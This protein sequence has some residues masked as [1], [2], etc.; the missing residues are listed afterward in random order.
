[1]RAW[2]TSMSSS[3]SSQIASQYSSKAGWN[4]RE[5]SVVTTRRILRPPVPTVR[6]RVGTVRAI[7]EPAALE[8]FS[9]PV[10]AWFETS[11]PRA[12]R[13][14][15][16][17][18]GDRSPGASTRCCAPPPGSG[19]TLA[20]FLWA[21]DRFGTGHAG[22]P[23][24]A[25]WSTSR[26][27][28]RSRSTSRRTCA[29]RSRGIA[30][31][32]ERLGVPFASRRSGCAPA[33]RAPTERRRW[34]APARHPHHHARVALPHA[35]LAGARDA[36]RGA[37]RDRRRDPR[38]RA[39]QARRPPGAHPRTPRAPRRLP[40]GTLGRW[41]R[42]GPAD[43]SSGSASRP[44]S[45]RSRWSPGSSAATGPV[46]VATDPVPRR[47]HGHDR[48]RGDAQGARRRGR[49]ARRRHGRP[50]RDGHPGPA[51][52]GGHRR[53]SGPPAAVDLA[54]DA[55]GAA[56]AWSRSTARRWCSSTPAGWP[57][58]SRA[59]STSSPPSSRGARGRWTSGPVAHV[60]SGRGGR[61]TARATSWSRRTTDRCRANAG[62]S[63][64]TSSSG[65][66]CGGWWRPA[67]SSS[68]ST[69]ERSTWSSR[70]SRPVRSPRDSSASGAPATR[71]A[72]P[73]GAGSSRSTGRTCSRRRWSSSGCTT[74]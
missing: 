13:G 38:P 12:H 67:R 11:F 39:H 2:M 4:S 26:R 44:P 1:M 69:W 54:V 65:A 25:A 8:R 22:R 45:V 33:T 48:R 57:S 63:S 70:S 64:R 72:R 55:P 61:P 74:G 42:P 59:G 37:E 71:S 34:S 27:C 47:C 6:D 19:K 50:G 3:C 15:G 58:G 46:A 51:A 30:L 35:H 31:A 23:R 49:R 14:P 66:T 36:R 68:A 10:R 9:A 52:D 60:D 32:A 28:G 16:A 5:R 17:A 62:C 18:P 56:L 41:P 21:I 43:P 53:P 20:A 40:P 7:V 29:A 24:R 73:A